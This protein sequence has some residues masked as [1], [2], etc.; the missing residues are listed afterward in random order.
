MSNYIN[1]DIKNYIEQRA[2]F[3]NKILEFLDEEVEEN[4]FDILKYFDKIKSQDNVFDVKKILFLLR[5]IIDYHQRGNNFYTRM[6]KILIYFK[7]EIKQTFTNADLFNF[8]SQSK[9]ALLI[10]LENEMIKMDDSIADTLKQTEQ[11]LNYFWPNIVS[12]YSDHKLTFNYAE[13]NEKRK[14]GVN[15]DYLAN[16]IRT[17]QVEEFISFVIRSSISLNS[18]ICISFFETNNL[19]MNKYSRPTLIEYATY[20]GSI[21]IFQFLQRNDVELT[22]SLW[23]YAIH[24]NNAEI[25][26]IL[27]GNVELDEKKCEECFIEAIKCHHNYFVKYFL[28]TKELKQFYLSTY[29]EN[30]NYDVI[31][32][33]QNSYKRWIYPLSCLYYYIRSNPEFVDLLFK[34][35]YF[36]INR[37]ENNKTLLLMAMEK[38]QIDV[39][40]LLALNPK[41]DT[42]AKFQKNDKEYTALTFA[43]ENNQV[44][45]VK[46]I[47]ENENTDPNTIF[48]INY[49]NEKTALSTAIENNQNEIIKLLISDPKCDANTRFKMNCNEYTALTLAIKNNQ[50]EIVKMLLENQNVDPNILFYISYGNEET[51]LSIAIEN[52]QNEIIELLLKNQNTDPNIVFKKDGREYTAL[53]MAIENNKFELVKNLLSNENIDPNIKL[54]FENKSFTAFS[55]S[56][57]KEN[58]ELFKLLASHP[59]TDPNIILKID[60]FTEK[61]AASMIIE[62]NKE[63]MTQLLLSNKNFNPNTKFNAGDYNK[64]EK[65]VLS[66]AYETNNAELFSQLL[67]REDF[68]PNVKLVEESFNNDT[69]YNESVEKTLL[70]KAIENNNA[71]MVKQLLSIPNIDINLKHSRKYK[72]SQ[73]TIEERTVLKLAVKK[74]NREI[75]NLLLNEEKINLMPIFEG[76]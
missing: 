61:T 21:Q 1:E 76:M 71:D 51:A 49:G 34:G 52:D 36:D 20:Y 4:N 5:T 26:H 75:I 65:T 73:R 8:F 14:L 31:P 67:S 69:L 63:E 16:L 74:G 46:I 13:Y 24:S 70:W 59:K 3:Q 18:N 66:I 9:L 39:V 6:E 27:E 45:F 54:S 19:L 25:F 48:H 57:E 11:D 41:C 55:M 32:V 37:I 47:L 35:S 56:I 72:E 38:Y 60:S 33:D 22:P 43:I 7:E 17:D 29:W 30:E 42:N 58:F 68:D 50:L 40:K 64:C 28:N 23:I 44:E 2:E 15:D 10:L 53:T 12:F 62:Q